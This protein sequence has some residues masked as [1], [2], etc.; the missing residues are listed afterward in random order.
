MPNLSPAQLQTLKTHLAANTATVLI[1]GVA[2]AINA[3]PQGGQNAQ[4]VADWYNLTASPAY[5]VWNPAT[6]L[7]SIR[8]A[9]DLSKYTPTDSPP[10]STNNVTGTNDALLYQ[11][12]AL[13]AQLQ[14]ANAY[15]LVQGEGTVD[16]TPQQLRQ[17][18]NDC[19]V[20]I[21]TGASG[22]NANAGWGTSGA[23]GAVRLAMQRSATNAEKL[24]SVQGAGAGAAGNVSG[25]ARGG[26]TNPDALVVVLPLTG[27][28]V[29]EA[30]AA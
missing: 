28:D 21:P 8:A 7:K 15:F 9:V 17:S 1:N 20:G 2:T 16:A 5:L 23:P 4:T 11:N 24:Y 10:A 29:L 18:F 26:T 30:W 3:V 14:Q 13:K 25:D 19:M 12:R 27:S 6:P 22:A